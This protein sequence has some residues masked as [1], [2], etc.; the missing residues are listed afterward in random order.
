[1][2]VRLLATGL[3]VVR[4][5]SPHHLSLAVASASRHHPSTSMGAGDDEKRDGERETGAAESP[6]DAPDDASDA[7]DDGG[8]APLGAIDGPDP[9]TRASVHAFLNRKDT[10][11]WVHA[12]VARKVHEHHAE[13]VAQD[14]LLE[15]AKSAWLPSARKAIR[16]W[17]RT[18]VDRAVADHHKKRKRR[19]RYEGRMPRPPARVDEGGQG[20]DDAP[21]ADDLGPSVDPREA[22]LAADALFFRRWMEDQV[23]GDPEERLTLSLMLEQYDEEETFAELA[24]RHG[25]SQSTL[26]KRVSALRAKYGERFKRYQ[27]RMFV[28]IALGVAIAVAIIAVVVYLLWPRGPKPFDITHDPDLTPVT[29]VPSVVLPPPEPFNNALPTQ[30]DGGRDKPRAPR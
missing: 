17:L 22:E 12:R 26:S 27:R 10:F 24:K 13:Q 7:A 9:P 1:M 21:D 15:A 30:P 3:P 11:A 28:M 6:T 18:I 23:A 25:I 20:A 4:E 19:S 29:P 2:D 16:S 5:G 8:G 14:A